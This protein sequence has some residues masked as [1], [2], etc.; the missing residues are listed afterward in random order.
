[1]PIGVKKEDNE[2][3]LMADED[4]SDRAPI[5]EALIDK[6]K[7]FIKSKKIMLDKYIK[8][9][10]SITDSFDKMTKY[11]GTDNYESLPFILE[12]METQM[13]SIEMFISKLNNEQDVLEEEK[14]E[15][16]EKIRI[17]KV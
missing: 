15:Y 12:K 4:I 6:W 2:A 8:N 7:F 17:L 3:A 1:M 13:S 14:R 16:E 5:L 11:L 9:S 10:T